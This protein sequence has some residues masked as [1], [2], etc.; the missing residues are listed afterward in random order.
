LRAIVTPLVAFDALIPGVLPDLA[1]PNS[2]AFI[3]QDV[4]TKTLQAHPKEAAILEK[5]LQDEKFGTLPTLSLY[6]MALRELE[7]RA[8]GMP[9]DN[10]ETIY[11]GFG[12][13]AAFNQRVHRYAGS[14]AA[15][16]YAQRN[17]TLTGHID[18]P[19]VMQ[20]NMFD[21]TV[22]ERFHSVYP[23]QVRAAGNDKLLTVLPPVGE[24]HCNFTDVQTISAFQTLVSKVNTEAH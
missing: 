5:R 3:P 20:W 17:V 18:T 8:G 15:M 1:A 10:R 23:D 12:D 14:P 21:P 22:P 16:A 13:D 2:P 11:H 4:F 7:R 6:Y 24:G 19:L 9:V